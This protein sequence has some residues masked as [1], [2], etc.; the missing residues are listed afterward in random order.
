LYSQIATLC[1][2]VVRPAYWL[3]T[4]HSIQAVNDSPGLRIERRDSSF[5]PLPQVMRVGGAG[6]VLDAKE[7]ALGGVNTTL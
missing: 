1:A 7:G 5:K 2:F 3:L 4:E 6:L